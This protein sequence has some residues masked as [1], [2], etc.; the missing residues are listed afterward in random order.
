MKKLK[1]FLAFVLAICCIFSNSTNDLTTVYADENGSE[2]ESLTSID[3]SVTINTNNGVFDVT[4]SDG[5]WSGNNASYMIT[6]PENNTLSDIGFSFTDPYNAYTTDTFTGWTV[7]DSAYTEIASYSTASD[8]IAHL[9]VTDNLTIEAKWSSNV[10][11][12][13]GYT[14]TIDACGGYFNHT[15]G[16]WGYMVDMNPYYIPENS[17]MNMEGYSISDPVCANKTFLGW[18]VFDENGNH[19]SANGYWSTADILSYTLA[20]ANVTCTAQWDDDNSGSNAILC[21]KSND[22]TFNID[23]PLNTLQI[24]GGYITSVPVNSTVDA[25]VLNIYNFQPYTTGTFN[26]WYL[27]DENGPDPAA[28]LMST[29]DVLAYQIPTSGAY[30]WADWNVSTPNEYNVNIDSNGGLFNTSYGNAAYL[31]YKIVENSSIDSY[32]YSFSDPVQGGMIFDGWD[33]YDANGNHLSTNGY[34]TTSDVLIHFIT[35]DITCTAQWSP[36][37]SNMNTVLRFIG[38][39]GRFDID[40]PNNSLYYIDSYISYAAIGS[41]VDN[42]VNYLYDP[43]SDHGYTFTG[44]LLGDEVSPY[45]TST[46]MTSMDVLS[47]QIPANGAYLWAQ[48]DNTGMNPP[49]G[50]MTYNAYFKANGGTFTV[51]D[52]ADNSTFTA[53]NYSYCS[54]EN[55]TVQGSSTITISDPVYWDANRA[56]KGW[57]VCTYDN[58]S[59]SG[60]AQIPGTSILTTAD[61]LAY[62]MPSQEI[63]FIAQWDG[64]DSDYMSSFTIDGYAVDIEYYN[65]SMGM[66]MYAPWTVTL[67]E[68][69]QTINSQISNEFQ[70]VT[71]PTTNWNGGT[72]EGWL[73]FKVEWNTNILGH[74]YQDYTLVSNKIYTTA[75]MLA[76]TVPAYDVTY[77]A[78]WSDI[79][80]NEYYSYVN[81]TQICINGLGGDFTITDTNN[82]SINTI[83]YNGMVKIGSNLLAS[84]Y[85]LSN[86]IMYGHIFKGWHVY[87]D[88]I[89]ATGMCNRTQITNIGTNGLATTADILNYQIL[90]NQVYFEAQ[91]EIDTRPQVGV[92]IHANEGSFTATQNENVNIIEGSQCWGN[93]YPAGS[94]LKDSAPSLDISAPVYWNPNRAFTGWMACTWEEIQHPDGGSH[95][96]YVQ[97]PETSIMTTADMLTYTIPDHDLYFIAQWAGDDSDYM[98]HVYIMGYNNATFEFNDIWGDGSKHLT[99]TGS[100]GNDLRE[101]GQS[102]EVQTANRFELVSEPVRMD[103]SGASFQGWLEYK[104]EWK[105]NSYGDS[106]EDYTLVNSTL[107]TTAQMLSKPVPSYDVAYVAKWSDIDIND[108]FS[109]VNKVEVG[110]EGDGGEFTLTDPDGKTGTACGTNWQVSIDSKVG[111]NMTVGDPV[112][113]GYIF[114]GWQLN[115]VDFSN[116]G[117]VFTPISGNLMTTQETLDYTVPNFNIR[118]IAQWDADSRPQV[119]VFIQANGGTVTISQTGNTNAYESFGNMYPAGSALKDYAPAFTISTPVYW[120]PNRAFTG[121]MACTY[122]QIQHPD[123]SSHMEHVQIPGTSIMTTA[124]MLAYAIPGHDLY[125]I[126]QWS[127]D[128]SDYMSH[129]YIMGYEGARFEYNDIGVDGSK[130]LNETDTWGHTLRENGQSIEDQ[131]ANYFEFVNDPVRGNNPN[132]IFQGWLEYKV[133]WKTNS[134]GN[135]YE[136]YTLVNGTPITT[137]QMLAKPVPAYDVAYVAKWSDI[138]TNE[139]F[140]WVNSVVVEFD[141]M[142]GSFAWTAS[143]GQTGNDSWATRQITINSKVGST[144]TVGNPVCSGFIFKGWQVNKLE[145]KDNDEVFLTPVSTT[146]LT[147]QEVLDYTVPNFNIR[148]VAKWEQDSRQQVI[149]NFECMGGTFDVTYG[150]SNE[151]YPNSTWSNTM[152]PVGSSYANENITVTDPKYWYPARQFLGWKVCQNVSVTLPDGSIRDELQQLPGTKIL[153]TTEAL[154]YTVPSHNIYFLAQWAGDDSD[155]YSNITIMGYEQEFELKETYYDDN[156]QPTTNTFTT[157]RWDISL[158]ETIKTVGN[159]TIGDQISGWISF[160]S[161]PQKTNAVLEGWVKFKVT[162][163]TDAEGNEYDVY[164]LIDNTLYKTSDIFNQEVPHYDVAFVA[165]WSDIEFDEYFKNEL[166]FVFNANGGTMNVTYTDANGQL[167]AENVPNIMQNYYEDRN[168]AAGLNRNGFTFDAIYTDETCLKFRGWEVYSYAYIDWVEMPAGDELNVGDPDIIFKYFD[169]YTNDQGEKKD[170]YIGLVYP[171][172]RGT[173]VSTTQLLALGYDTN[174]YASAIWGDAH[175]PGDAIRENIVDATTEKAGSYDKVVYCSKCKKELSRT[176]CTIEILKQAI[177]VEGSSESYQLETKTLLTEVPNGLTFANVEAIYSELKEEATNNSNSILNANGKVEIEILDVELQVLNADEE[178]EKVENEDFPEKGI[179]ILLPYPEG[180]I[181]ENYTFVVTHMITTGEDAGKVEYLTPVSTEDGLRV[182]VTSLSPIG[183]IYQDTTAPVI[184]GVTEGNTYC[185]GQTITIT[186]DSSFNVTVNGQTI[187]LDENN[188]Y[189]LFADGSTYEIIATDEV[190]NSSSIVDITVNANHIDENNDGACDICGAY[191]DGIGAKLVGYTLSLEGNIGV[192]FYMQLS[193][194]VLADAN[195]YMNFTLGGNDYLQIPVTE[196]TTTIVNNTTYYVFKCGVPVKDMNTEITAQIILSDG[197]EGSEFTYTV[198]EYADYILKNSGIYSSETIAL[199]NAMLSFGDYAAAYFA[200]ETI[201]ATPEM[202]AITSETLEKYQSTFTENSIYSGSSLLLKSNTILRHYFTEEV[203][204]STKKGNL[205]YIDSE[206]IPAHELG[207]EIKI[208]VDNIEITYNPLSYAYIA[209]SRD[210]IEDENLRSLIRAMYLYHQTALAYLKTTTN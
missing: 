47:C 78:K 24:S 13:T 127:G 124:D 9:P 152:I 125:F 40:L 75:E 99:T 159:E 133:E 146:L 163:K 29:T 170:R 198:K 101:N 3:Y 155:Y 206:G 108:Y 42:Y 32:G 77:V 148:F 60:Y 201:A 210:N 8:L 66:N 34:W 121:W 2:P 65:P 157:D 166:Q 143:D 135:S 118:F 84:G 150:N 197:R 183:I 142:G 208:T 96:E 110:F 104:V 71:D 187:A 120:N 23:T 209:L 129:V 199:V 39:A 103:N 202:L 33:V 171:V 194:E 20:T 55:S 68:D 186:D 179:E 81:S 176:T 44:W 205:Y 37:S 26:G 100:W 137:A 111:S 18:E 172:L 192:N 119:N 49:I 70:L 106:Y 113:Q 203:T 138:E 122:E 182:T 27:G 167:R 156:N 204:G 149:A 130:H 19:L 61:A 64:K 25:N 56:F 62:T 30:F 161:E 53:E 88:M 189:T 114:K 74:T 90:G 177:T 76:Q 85:T 16:F 117:P 164:T 126:A 102:I 191:L 123:G 69:G 188:T 17:C 185:G 51:T 200:D 14:L 175:T 46:L 58:M 1:Q 154:N 28:M 82:Q 107:Y 162:T 63:I 35:A 140:S 72:F 89:D 98:S 109:W 5:T 41:T 15:N 174:Y 195:A 93:T 45:P 92:F 11:E 115:R 168:I 83:Y 59:D 173:S 153:T 178:Y 22:G 165:K 141:A 160:N 67:R 54:E 207:K 136:D 97:I 139:Y 94:T 38:N 131:T 31:D 4:D 144:L 151:F 147:T 95:F 57:M 132:A 128:D 134:Y 158:C 12:N 86:P 52:S 116:N 87:E 73:E 48:W 184:A 6:V 50:G 181:A 180:I 193:D 105:T 190:G 7:Y 80:I 36:D 79:N 21:F 196:A 43:I 169:T 145:F 10:I 91:W 112:R